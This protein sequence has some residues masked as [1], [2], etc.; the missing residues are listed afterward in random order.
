MKSE[1]ELWTHMISMSLSNQDGIAWQIQLYE[2]VDETRKTI[3]GGMV[4]TIKNGQF[5]EYEYAGKSH[6]YKLCWDSKGNII[7]FRKKR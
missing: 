7:V 2:Y 6:S 3:R 1:W 5:K 4:G